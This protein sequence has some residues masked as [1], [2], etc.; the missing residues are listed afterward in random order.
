MEH[1]EIL[2]CVLCGEKAITTAA[3]IPVCEKH[4][5]EYDEEGQ[6]YLTYRPFFE[7]LL[8]AYDQPD[9]DRARITVLE[10]AVA[11]KDQL[12]MDIT[13][14]CQKRGDQID[15]LEAALREI[16]EQIP[17][18]RMESPL[19]AMDGFWQIGKIARKALEEIDDE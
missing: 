3:H 13:A 12:I 8:R 17:T 10:E 4:W 16:K 15:K 19:T 7:R 2:V 14:I 5:Q 6:Q 1:P 11:E 9:A 18:K